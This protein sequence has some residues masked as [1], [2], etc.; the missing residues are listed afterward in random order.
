MFEKT[1][2]VEAVSIGIS[3]NDFWDMSPRTIKLISE[4]YKRRIQRIDNLIWTWFGNYGLSA[5][6]VAVE[7][8]LAGQKAKSKYIDKPVLQ[9]IKED[10]LEDSLSEEQLKK[11][12]ELFMM[13]LLTMKSN[14]EINHPKAKE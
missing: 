9:Q 1:W 13:T 6:S 10:K 4:G 12:R 14:F 5:V 2:L 8:N 11:K 7:H 3:H